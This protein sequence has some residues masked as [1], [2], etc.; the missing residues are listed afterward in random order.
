MVKNILKTI[1]L[2]IKIMKLE[3]LKKDKFEAFKENEIQNMLK[4][5]GG[6]ILTTG[7]NTDY[8]TSAT[9]GRYTGGDGTAY[10]R[11]DGPYGG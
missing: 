1:N 4:V 2:K 5:V 10:D 3:S 7:G 8:Y 6:K 9:R 11:V